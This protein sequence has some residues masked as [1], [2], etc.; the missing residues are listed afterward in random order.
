[1]ID[2]MLTTGFIRL[3]IPAHTRTLTRARAHTHTHTHTHTHIRARACVHHFK[4]TFY[5]TA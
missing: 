5:S 1:L 3:C 2:E 4:F